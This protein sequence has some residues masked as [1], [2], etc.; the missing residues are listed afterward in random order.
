MEHAVEVT[1]DGRTNRVPLA[2][3]RPD[4]GVAYPNYLQADQ[5][6]FFIA[7]DTFR[8]KLGMETSNQFIIAQ[9]PL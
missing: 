4:V 1:A 8:L 9:K 5:S 2:C 7:L 3:H 6:G